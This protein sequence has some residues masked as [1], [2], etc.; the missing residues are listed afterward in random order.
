MRALA[1]VVSLASCASPSRRPPDHADPAAT[2]STAAPTLTRGE[3]A[4]E[5][6]GDAGGTDSLTAQRRALLGLPA[7]GQDAAQ[8]HPLRKEQWA[9]PEA[10]GARFVLTDT[11]YAASEDPATVGARRSAYATERLGLI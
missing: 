5:S 11:T 1:L 4:G 10:V 2:S 8:L 3:D 9:D 6:G 7:P